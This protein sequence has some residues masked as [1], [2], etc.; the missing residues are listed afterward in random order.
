MQEAL[1]QY[2]WKNSLFTDREY[3]ADSGEKVSIIETGIH[4]TDGGPDFTNAKIKINDTLW[5]GNIELHRKTSEWNLHKHNSNAAYDNVILHVSVGTDAVCK[6]SKGRRIPCI[7]ISFDPKIEERYKSLLEDDSMIPC[8]QSLNKLDTSIIG[9]WMSALTIERLL[10]KTN[11][12]Q[13]L[14]KLTKNNW[15]ETFYINLA[16]SFGLKINALPFEML[17]KYTPLKVISKHTQSLFELE[18]IFFGQAGLL[19]KPYLDDYQESLGKEYI[20]FTKKYSLKGIEPHVWK[21]LRLRPSNFPT[22]RIAQ[23]CALMHKSER[24][25]SFTMESETIEKLLETYACSVS[26]YW[27]NHYKF[28]TVAK[29]KNKYLGLNTRLS[30]IINTIV[31]FMFIYGEY[32]NLD[33]LKE[34]AIRLL[35]EIPAEVN[36][37]V[38][39]WAEYNITCRNGAESQALIQLTSEYCLRKRCLE[40]QI[41]NLVLRKS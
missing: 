15:E 31:P 7:Q 39:K 30:L 14:L 13:N 12:I 5:A 27:K 24:L 2:I 34:K 23:F 33:K 9:F 18:A 16:R 11:Y 10:S 22:L 3:I 4:N 32:K 6:N 37:I 20:Y 26:D 35:E 36:S 8:Y 19:Q 1:L 38:K 21:Y 40:C 29:R 17:I 28:G 41:G 25:F